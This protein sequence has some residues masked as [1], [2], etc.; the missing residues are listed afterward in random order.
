M[1]RRNK[2]K[3]VSKKQRKQEAHEKGN[4]R[5]ELTSEEERE[6]TMENL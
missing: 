6:D 1:F 2:S 3:R 5:A 4:K